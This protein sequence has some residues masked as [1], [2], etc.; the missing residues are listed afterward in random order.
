MGD[1]DMSI[2]NSRLR[3]DILDTIKQCT[4]YEFVDD[5]VNINELQVD[6]EFFLEHLKIYLKGLQLSASKIRGKNIGDIV[7]LVEKISCNSSKIKTLR[8]LFIR[9]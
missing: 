9:L 8:V 5:N 1:I 7:L 6:A 3:E 4:S 2:D